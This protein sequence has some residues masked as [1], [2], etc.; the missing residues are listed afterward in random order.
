MDLRMYYQKIREWETKIVDEFPIVASKET[1]DGGKAGTMTE[2]P[3]ALAAKLIVDGMAELATDAELENFRTA[4]A[5]A[6]RLAES[7]LATTA[8]M[9]LTLVPKQELDSLRANQV[10]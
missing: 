6:Q 1:G 4:V 2:V 8:A 9:Q 3:K 5:E 10:R 7:R